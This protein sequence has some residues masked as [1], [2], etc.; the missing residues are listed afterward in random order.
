M[1]VVFTLIMLQV[2][3][4][5]LH[6]PRTPLP[7]KPPPARSAVCVFA[8]PKF[9]RHFRCQ[10]EARCVVSPRTA[11]WPGPASARG[12][13]TP[14]G[15]RRVSAPHIH[16][17][18]SARP[19]RRAMRHGPAGAAPRSYDMCHSRKLCGRWVQQP[20][21]ASALAKHTQARL[22]L[23][24]PRHSLD[25]TPRAAR[26]L[27]RV[28]HRDAAPAASVG[29]FLCLVQHTTWQSVC[30]RWRPAPLRGRRRAGTERKRCANVNGWPSCRKPLR[31]A[32][33]IDGRV[34]CCPGG[35]R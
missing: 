34:R 23:R 14:D 22:R 1:L 18:T 8:W 16:P 24:S 27:R 20:R 26:N 9:A 3:Y 33:V 30:A 31:G 13:R 25:P 15:R 11:R 28:P 4:K 10:A 21:R 2:R 7:P 19:G 32:Q 12:H 17:G 5:P 35:Y 6:I 29:G